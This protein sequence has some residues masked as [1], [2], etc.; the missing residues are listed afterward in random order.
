VPVIYILFMT[1]TS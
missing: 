1:R